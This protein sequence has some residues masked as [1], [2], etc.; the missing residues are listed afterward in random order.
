MSIIENWEEELYDSTFDTIYEAL[1]E[2]YKKG[3]LTIEELD[4]NI[5]EQQQILLNAFF[6]G[7]TKSVYCNAVVDA[8][9]FVRSLITQ[10]KLT[11]ENL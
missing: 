8:H 6:E 4:R 7:E 5:A 3:L 11:V 9:Q 1:V 10:G 2:E